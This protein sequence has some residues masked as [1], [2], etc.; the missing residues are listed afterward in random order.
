M[1]HRDVNPSNIGFR[2]DGTAVLFDFNNAKLIEHYDATKGEL[3]REM[4]G[5]V[6][7]LRYQSPEMTCHNPTGSGTDVYSFAIL[8]FEIASLQVPY[9]EVRMGKK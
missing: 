5:D 3:P 6:G 1:I 7:N 2:D 4:T 9:G 8:A